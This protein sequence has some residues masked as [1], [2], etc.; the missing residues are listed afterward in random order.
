MSDSTAGRRQ[1]VGR[2]LIEIVKGDITASPGDA[3]VNAAN[4][5]LR[6]GG[7]V[8]GAI[9]RAGGP[10]ILKECVEKYP[11]GLKPGEAAVTCAGRLAVQFVIHAV[12]PIWNGGSRGEARILENAY[13]ASLDRAKEA[14]VRH[15]SFP[16]ISTGAYGY[17]LHEAA[18]IALTT[19]A[20]V[21][22][23]DPGSLTL[24]RF[25]LF[26]AATYAAYGERMGALE[27]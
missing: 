11:N 15:I 18:T 12:G 23:N 8:D 9:H 24:I 17:P 14:R 22:I 27:V 10:D 5:R 13:R 4:P 16:S 20:D 1:K 2:G 19:C 21:L 7:G 3:I 6:G 26:D 25:V